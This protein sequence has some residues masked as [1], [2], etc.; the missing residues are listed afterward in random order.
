MHKCKALAHYG[1]VTDEYILDRQAGS[2]KNNPAEHGT[3][4]RGQ[5]GHCS[6]FTFAL[7]NHGGG[8]ANRQDRSHWD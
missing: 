3:E 8:K 5:R 4:H 2:G 1:D 6:D 7:E